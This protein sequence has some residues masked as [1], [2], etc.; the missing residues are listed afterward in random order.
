[1]EKP[2]LII[3]VLFVCLFVCVGA[4]TYGHSQQIKECESLG[5]VVVSGSSGSKLCVDPA[6]LINSQSK[7][8]RL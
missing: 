5:G 8:E 6:M 2:D 1:M 7:E 3:V 4:I